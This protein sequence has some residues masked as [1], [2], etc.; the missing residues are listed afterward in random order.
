[1]CIWDTCVFV[2]IIIATYVADANDNV[3]LHEFNIFD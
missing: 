1:M 3:P 2:C